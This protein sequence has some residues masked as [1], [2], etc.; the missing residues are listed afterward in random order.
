MHQDPEIV[1]AK[2]QK[3]VTVL[4]SEVRRLKMLLNKKE[5]KRVVKKEKK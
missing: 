5:E 1:I 2:L 4:Q 3:E